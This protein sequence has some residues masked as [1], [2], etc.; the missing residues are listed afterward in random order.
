MKTVSSDAGTRLARAKW[1]M[2][3]WGKA[4]QIGREYE[5]RNLARL[6]VEYLRAR[7]HFIEVAEGL[8]DELV[9]QNFH[10]MEDGNGQGKP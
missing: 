9:A 6:H 1:A 3:E 4:F 8:A 10:R 2:D 7:Q 5:S